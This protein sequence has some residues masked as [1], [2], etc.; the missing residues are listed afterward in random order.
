[1]LFSVTVLSAANRPEIL[2]A[3]AA[4]LYPIQRELS[5][6][7][8]KTL[9]IDLKFTFSGS[10]MLARQIENGA[11]Y[12]LYLSANESFVRN[13]ASRGKLL[14]DTVT[15]YAIGRLGLWSKN[16]KVQRLEDL[17]AV[18]VVHFALPNPV[19][20]PYGAAAREMLQALG[21]WKQ[22]EAKVVYGENV[23][24][25]LQFAESGNADACITA[26][27]LVRARGGTLLPA[28]HATIRQV[29]GVVTSSTKR[30]AAGKVLQFLAGPG[31]RALLGR[32]GFGTP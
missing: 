23:E 1:V 30:Q 10:G 13:L 8:A 20:A 22:V 12:D 3:A 27:S 2:V 17:T 14:P 28:R 15:I 5:E 26:W 29:G 6:A 24:Q 19:H 21:L 11:P 32:Y 4:D 7:A 31:G 18:R 9:G 16:G 25:T